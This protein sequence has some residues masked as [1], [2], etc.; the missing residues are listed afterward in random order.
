MRSL[1]LA[2]EAF[3]ASIGRISSGRATCRLDDIPAGRYAIALH[4]DANTNGRVDTGSFG[5]ATEGLG[6]S[7]DAHG[8]F[9]PPSFADAA[10]SFDH[11]ALS[12][13]ARIGYVF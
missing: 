9:G 2:E 13:S 1:L 3:A 5:I 12:L 7:N 4:H 8:S 10:F 6:A 11:S